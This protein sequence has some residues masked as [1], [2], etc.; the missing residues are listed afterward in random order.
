MQNTGEWGR[1]FPQALSPLAYNVSIAQDYFPLS[2][3]DTTR[4]G[5][6]WYETPPENAKVL[7]KSVPTNSDSGSDELTKELFSCKES[8]KPY[9]LI[10]QELEFYRSQRIPPPQFAFPI[11]HEHRLAMRNPRYLWERVC[12][13]CGKQ[14]N[15]SI[16]PERSEVVLCE[17]CFRERALEEV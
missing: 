3:L 16:A 4:L 10:R 7:P 5:Y 12:G 11:R 17:G 9:K 13:E 2:R 1:F 8:G 6:R 15:T 14:I